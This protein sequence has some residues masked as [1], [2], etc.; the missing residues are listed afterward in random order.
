M[1]QSLETLLL[2][3][4]AFS[5]FGNEF[6]HSFNMMNLSTLQLRNCPSSLELLGAL[7]EQG[8]TPKLK[9]FELVIDWDC[10][11]H[12]T[13]FEEEQTEV[14]F[15]FLVSFKGLEDLFL[16]LTQPLEWY[17][18]ANSIV[19]HQ[20]T[21]KRLILHER[22]TPKGKIADGGIPWHNSGELLFHDSRLSC[23]GTSGPISEMESSFAQLAVKPRCQILHIKMSWIDHHKKYD[24]ELHN[25]DSE[26]SDSENFKRLDSWSGGNFPS[27]PRAETL[28]EAVDTAQTKPSN[29]VPYS[30]TQGLTIQE[31]QISTGTMASSNPSPLNPDLAHFLT[32]PWC[33]TLLSAPTITLLPALSR[34]PKRSTEDSLFAATLRTP[35]TIHAMLSFSAPC[36]A[37]TAASTL[38]GPLA[39]EVSTL[40]S[41]GAGLG[42]RV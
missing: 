26:D 29:R 34:V 1:F 4:V 21:V 42:K 11:H 40:M 17:L 37:P 24:E 32:I 38:S 30:E 13:D 23:F 6:G 7:L 18:I 25:V 5:P 33:A 14:I 35:S 28:N 19:N 8:I 3:G 2:V 16:L 27:Y 12:Y 15:R 9:S 20:S 41:L 10:L 36:S 39:E 31:P 22:D